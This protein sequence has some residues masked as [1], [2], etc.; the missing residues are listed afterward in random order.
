M[1]ESHVLF[2]SFC[3]LSYFLANASRQN[4]KALPDDGQR[5]LKWQQT[6]MREAYAET[7]DSGHI[8]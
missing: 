8:S 4:P 5:A 6:V 1:A 7:D 2:H 3:V